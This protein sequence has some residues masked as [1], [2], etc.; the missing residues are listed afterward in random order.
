LKK[1]I[2]SLKHWYET[3]EERISV[4]SLIGGF[5]FDNLTLQRIDNVWDNLWITFNILLSGYCIIMLNRTSGARDASEEHGFWL[6]NILQFSFGALLGSTFV[7]YLRS[8]TLAVTW[9]FLVL[10]LAVILANEFFQKK[11]AKLA[12]QLSFLY[13]SIFS[14][15]IF[16]VPL[17]VKD[18]GPEI[19]VLSGGASLLTLWVYIAVLGKF[20][21][22]KFLESRTH[23]WMFVTVIFFGINVLYFTNLIP[24]IPLSL[25]DAGIYHALSTDSKGEYL[26]V[27]EKQGLLETFALRKSVH[28]HEGE[29]LYAYTSIY[30]PGSLNTDIVHEWQHKDSD[31]KWVTVT[32]IPLYLSGGRSSGFRTY[33]K[34]EAFTAGDWRVDVKTSRGQIIGRINFK[35]VPTTSDV[36]LITEVK[37]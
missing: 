10:M 26:V 30:S 34:K 18:I 13:F 21:T 5:I 22:Q 2:H 17:V 31:G 28:W 14:F 8:S 29:T 33:S 12:F 9:P 23:I 15:F 35:I 16:L 37:S 27:G 25:K 11:Y 7:F 3:Y 1:K 4:I 36:K 19:F 32:R 20:A 6:P 24:P